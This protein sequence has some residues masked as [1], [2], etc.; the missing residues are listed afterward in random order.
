MQ[1]KY[2]ITL[3]NSVLLQVQFYA[4][5][6][7]ENWIILINNVLLQVLY[8]NVPFLRFSKVDLQR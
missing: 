5:K 2:W 7:G 6:M 3:I 8:I 4:T 1:N